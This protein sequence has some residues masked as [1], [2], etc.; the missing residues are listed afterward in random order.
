MRKSDVMKKILFIFLF[1]FT[2]FSIIAQSPVYFNYQASVKDD[3]GSPLKDQLVSIKFSVLEGADSGFT[4]YLEHHQAISSQN[5]I[6]NLKIGNGQNVL[7]SLSDLDWAKKLYWVEVEMDKAGGNDYELVS[8]A[9]LLSV[10]YALHA[11]TS[12]TT[13]TAD[14]ALNSQ[15]SETA[16]Y[17]QNSNFAEN[18]NYS[19]NS[20]FA[21]T[22]E[23]VINVDDADANP[24]NEIQTL[25]IDAHM[26]SIS[27]G[28]T[29]Q[30]PTVSDSGDDDP[31]NELQILELY[32]DYLSIS[33][34]NQVNLS[35]YKSPWQSSQQWDPYGIFYWGNVYMDTVS[36]NYR[37]LVG[38]NA[39]YGT[40]IFEK[41]FIMT[42]LLT[43]ENLHLTPGNVTLQNDNFMSV[44][45][46]SKFELLEKNTPSEIVRRF[47]IFPDSVNMYNENEIKTLQFT[48]DSNL[49]F[50]KINL[51]DGAGNRNIR[52][53]S[54]FLPDYGQLP[55]TGGI[56]LFSSDSLTLRL[57]SLEDGSFMKFYNKDRVAKLYI[58]TD[59]PDG[60]ILNIYNSLGE[61]KIQLKTNELGEGS[62]ISQG[63]IFVQDSDGSL[64]AS[65]DEMGINMWN[66]QGFIASGIGKSF[67]GSNGGVIFVNDGN[68]YSNFIAGGNFLDD[69]LN[70]GI[71]AIY[72]NFGVIKAGL[73]VDFQ[74]VGSFFGNEYSMN[75]QNGQQRGLWN[76]HDGH[77]AGSFYLFGP[78][79]ELN[80]SMDYNDTNYNRGAIYVYNEEGAP[81]VGLFIR[82][83]TGMGELF[84]DVKHFRMDY[85]G[86]AEKEIWYASLEGPE[87]AAYI[88]GT[89][90][91]VNGE[92]FI[93]FPDHFKHVSNT[94]SMTVQITP[95]FWDTFGL[96]VTEKTNSGF[97]VKELK[98]GQGNFEFDWEVKCVRQGFEDYKIINDKVQKKNPQQE[99]IVDP[100]L[101]HVFNK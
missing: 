21:D 81:K 64:S 3:N 61:S 52:F 39:P 63:G 53:G 25:S 47:A 73:K 27:G 38:D 2:V 54:N 72:N 78:N 60:G 12:A 65:I 16:L 48:T 83:S 45:G 85:P 6:I 55:H 36:I 77:D 50:G 4:V 43:D 99:P 59:G 46:H 67:G 89:S 86:M 100:G 9:Q 92:A 37:L 88:R 84:A 30:L 56:Q 49:G 70:G 24:E 90:K 93:T 69:N 28:N 34:G 95:L 87:A 74:S 19:E 76:T 82:E 26:L 33:Q 91:L 41:D 11:N 66:D 23:Y 75:G 97:R 17:A 62:I 35:S 29:I 80:I 10:P 57:E 68:D 58:G 98:G 8:S 14:F 31:A 101:G 96:A 5:G 20:N 13:D 40:E 42:N 22:A 1:I 18:S 71:V 7:G 15:N 51:Y 79:N 44:L 94:G 32:D